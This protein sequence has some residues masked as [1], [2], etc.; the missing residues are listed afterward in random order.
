MRLPKI[1]KLD[2]SNRFKPI[3]IFSPSGWS[4]IALHLR[5]RKE[6]CGSIIPLTYW[7]F[8]KEWIKSVIN[9]RASRKKNSRT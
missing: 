6:D 3:F 8:I 1:Y 9:S 4:G 2:F 5:F 7:Q